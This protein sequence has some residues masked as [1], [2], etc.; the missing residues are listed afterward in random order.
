MKEDIRPPQPPP[1]SWD[2]KPMSGPCGPEEPVDACQYIGASNTWGEAALD[3]INKHL[4]WNNLCGIKVEK[5]GILVT[6]GPHIV[7]DWD[8]EGDPP[9]EPSTQEWL[10]AFEEG[11]GYPLL[12]SAYGCRV[13]YAG[14]PQDSGWPETLTNAFKGVGTYHNIDGPISGYCGGEATVPKATV[15]INWYSLGQTYRWNIGG[16]AAGGVFYYW[17]SV[18]GTACDDVECPEPGNSCID[19]FC[20]APVAPGVPVGPEFPP[21]VTPPIVV[22]P[23]EPTDPP[24][25]PPVDPE[26]PDCYV[27]DAE[28]D[29]CVYDFTLP[30]CDGGGTIEPPCVVTAGCGIVGIITGNCKVDPDECEE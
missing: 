2:G 19:G 14:N 9:P 28:L 3:Y 21:G 23:L 11:F 18:H 10:A 8:G 25:E 30:G 7:V 29:K 4:G 16:L 5:R 13:I 27:Y 26:C 20:F 15:S 6:S 1:P 22:E 12:E 24:V 17:S